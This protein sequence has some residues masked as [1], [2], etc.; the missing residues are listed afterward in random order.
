MALCRRGRPDGARVFQLRD[1]LVPAGHFEAVLH[2]AE[3]LGWGPPDTW[4]LGSQGPEL[5]TQEKVAGGEN[6]VVGVTSDGHLDARKKDSAT[7]K[8]TEFLDGRAARRL[9]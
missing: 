5:Q 3:V 9:L 6:F 2:E 4:H 1:E 7:A 8:C